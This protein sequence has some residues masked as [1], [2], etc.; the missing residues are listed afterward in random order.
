[1]S[2]EIWNAIAV[3][4]DPRVQGRIDYPLGLI[5]LVSL[6]ATISGCDDWEQIE[7]YASNCSK[8]LMSLHEKLSVKGL[9]IIN[10]RIAVRG[11]CCDSGVLRC[12]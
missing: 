6:Y 10:C 1:M 11:L 8:N 9:I 3:V 7:D 4:K 5:L 2:A 12:Y